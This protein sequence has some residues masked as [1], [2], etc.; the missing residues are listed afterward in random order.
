[1]AS[2]EQYDSTMEPITLPNDSGASLSFVGR[3]CA[4]NSFFDEETGVLTQQKLY[5]TNNGHTAYAVVRGDG[6]SKE[7]RAYL[8]RREGQTCR[9]NNGLFDVTVN[10]RD[11]LLAV[12]GLCG[13][14]ESI[15][16]EEFFQDMLDKDNAA[17]G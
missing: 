11:L 15:Q 4:E 2:N 5:I 9:I 3:L 13:L 12:K 8:I 7:R 1:M 10:V 6:R 17:N 14:D 16:G